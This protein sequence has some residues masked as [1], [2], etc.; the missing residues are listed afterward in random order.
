MKFIGKNDGFT[1]Y[2]SNQQNLKKISFYS[3]LILII[4]TITLTLIFNIYFLVFL[5]IP[6]LG[7]LLVI[8]HSLLK[9]KLI[10]YQNK[11]NIEFK[12]K[13]QHLF[14]IKD[15]HLYKDYREI[16]NIQAIT[17]YLYKDFILLKQKNNYISDYII[18]NS[19]YQ[20]GSRE[21]F[22]AWIKNNNFK[23]KKRL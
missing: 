11:T 19:D 23:I 16:K 2:F 10:N 7:M 9:N 13:T 21:E 17:I 5:T 1:T 6:I 22:I 14:E 8:I 20:K 12:Q 18:H 15:N 4:P 3:F